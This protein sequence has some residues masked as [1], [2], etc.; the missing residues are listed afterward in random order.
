MSTSSCFLLFDLLDTESSEPLMNLLPES[1]ISFGIFSIFPPLFLKFFP[2]TVH[3][4]PSCLH[5]TL[6][7]SVRFVSPVPVSTVFELSCVIPPSRFSSV[8]PM[9]RLMY[10]TFLSS[11][12]RVRHRLVIPEGCGTISRT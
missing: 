5:A 1:R 6:P 11:D 9:T 7:L 12:L 2:T 10:D 8:I 3:V 4:T